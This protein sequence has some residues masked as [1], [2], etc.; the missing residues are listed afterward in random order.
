VFLARIG[1]QIKVLAEQQRDQIDPK[2]GSGETELL[3]FLQPGITETFHHQVAGGAIRCL[4][5]AA[6]PE[7]EA[8]LA[9]GEIDDRSG[10]SVG[11]SVE[12]CPDGE[13]E[14]REPA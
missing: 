9:H 12:D 2:S 7:T 10:A 13:E 4:M 5:A 8:A 3:G 1:H 14:D 11:G 6:Q